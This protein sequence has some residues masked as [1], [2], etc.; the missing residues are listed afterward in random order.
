MGFNIA[1][2]NNKKVFSDVCLVGC[3]LPIFENTSRGLKEIHVEAP[4]KKQKP[5]Y[6]FLFKK[7]KI[8][9]FKVKR[10]SFGIVLN[11]EMT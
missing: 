8:K 9:Y 10:S 2:N 11:K 4:V 5:V 6:L 1:Y 3:L 7:H